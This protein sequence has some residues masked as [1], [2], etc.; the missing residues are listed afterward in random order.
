MRS[1]VQLGLCSTKEQPLWDLVRKARSELLIILSPHR[2]L[3]PGSMGA[4][5]GSLGA[6]SPLIKTTHSSR[7]TPKDNLTSLELA[8]PGPRM[9]L[10]IFCSA[11]RLSFHKILRHL[12]MCDRN[13]CMPSHKTNGALHETSP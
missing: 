7:S 2:M 9:H 10:R 11:C 8:A 13:R 6:D 3:L 1:M 5:I 12:P 4:T